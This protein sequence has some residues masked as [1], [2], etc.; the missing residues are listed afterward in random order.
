MKDNKP[1]LIPAATSTETALDIATYI[2]SAVPWIGGPVSAVLGGIS[3]GRKFSRVK[4]VLEGLASDLA[5]LHSEK[6]EKYVNTEDFEELLEQTL[7]RVSEERSEEKRR[8]YRAFLT[9]AIESP[10][11]SYDEQIRFIR[12]LDILQPD[13]L[14]IVRALSQSPDPSSGIMGSPSSTLHRRLPEFEDTRIGELIAQLNDL[15]VTNMTSLMVMMT[16]SGAEDLRHSITPYG[17]RFLQYIVNDIS[18]P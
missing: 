4:E 18:I 12:T 17:K 3:I 5:E 16:A 13:H 11:E 9:N 10:G 6:S 8:I 15:R 2:A 14:K 7:K 1:D